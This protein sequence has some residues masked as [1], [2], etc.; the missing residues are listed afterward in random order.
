MGAAHSPILTRKVSAQRGSQI[1]EIKTSMRWKLSMWR[2]SLT[3]CHRPA[4]GTQAKVLQIGCAPEP[5]R[6]LDKTRNTRPQHSHFR[7][8]E[9]SQRLHFL[10]SSPIM[11]MLL[12]QGPHFWLK[13]IKQLGRS[14]RLLT[15][16][17]DLG[18]F[19]FSF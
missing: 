17:P 9:T 12:V 1:R 11:S 2:N 6:I 16:R 18:S 14:Y 4:G 5:P 7:F 15:R 13:E 10:M 19:V 3:D 8:T